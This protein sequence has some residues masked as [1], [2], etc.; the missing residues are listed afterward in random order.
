[1]HSTFH[2]RILAT[3]LLTLVWSLGQPGTARSESGWD[4]E[5]QSQIE[6]EVKKFGKELGNSLLQELKVLEAKLKRLNEDRKQDRLQ[7]ERPVEERV[8]E[9][10]ERLRVD[11][12]N[13]EA[14]FKLG[15]IYDSL[16]DGASAIIHTMEA[17]NLFVEQRQ[18]K[19]VAE[20]R[21]NLREYF[22]KY[23]FLPEDFL[24]PE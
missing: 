15:E 9:L 4:T 5:R 18:V 21:R 12:K 2:F 17:E 3:L 23:G 11:P 19:G 1:M 13:A 7:D 22:Q 10:K 24:L 20:A 14:H 6:E 16:G 8:N